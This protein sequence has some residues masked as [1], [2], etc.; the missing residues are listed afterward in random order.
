MGRIG[1]RNYAKE[2]EIHDAYVYGTRSYRLRDNWWAWLVIA[3]IF[4]VAIV[5]GS[6][7]N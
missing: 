1:K 6:F 5:V 2:R 3:G 7:L 4:A